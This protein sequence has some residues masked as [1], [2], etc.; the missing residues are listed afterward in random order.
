MGLKLAQIFL[1]ILERE[2]NWLSFLVIL[3]GGGNWLRFF[4]ISPE[5]KAPGE[6]IV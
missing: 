6:L 3:E 5:Q 1:V 2:E 4:F